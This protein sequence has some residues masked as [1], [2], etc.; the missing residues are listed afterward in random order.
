MKSIGTLAA[1]AVLFTAAGSAQAALTPTTFTLDSTLSQVTLQI[2]PSPGQ[3]G[4]STSNAATVHFSGDFTLGLAGSLN[5]GQVSLQGI[6][7]GS[8]VA[9]TPVTLSIPGLTLT[10]DSVALE[11]VGQFG[12]V[13]TNLAG[14]TG[15]LTT[16]TLFS[17]SGSSQV[18]FNGVTFPAQP[19]SILSWAPASAWDITLGTALGVGQPGN[20]QGHLHTQASLD[21][22][23]GNPSGGQIQ[24]TVDLWGAANYTPPAPVPA[25]GALWLFLSGLPALLRRGRRRA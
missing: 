12:K 11:D 18:T 2:V 15:T 20:L 21:L 13:S 10:L 7:A 4:Q 1:A 24:V 25:P 9:S 19:L 3:T 22:F 6:L 14:G 17:A 8:T 16:D 5:N 23:A